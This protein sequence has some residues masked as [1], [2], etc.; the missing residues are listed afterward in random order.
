MRIQILGP[1]RMWRDGEPLDPPP[2]AQR[3]LLGLLALAGGHP[4]SR[5]ELGAG[6]WSGPPPP[7]GVNLLHPHVKRLRRLLE[8][9][10]RPYADIGVVRRVGDGYALA[11]AESTV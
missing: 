9:D 3:A 11:V 5:T 1:V 6:I 7:S 4:V 10:R 2:P 8:P